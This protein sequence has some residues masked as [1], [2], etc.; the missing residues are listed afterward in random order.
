MVFGLLTIGGTEIELLEFVLESNGRSSASTA[1]CH[2]RHVTKSCFSPRWVST[3]SDLPNVKE[4]MFGSVWIRSVES[5]FFPFKLHVPSLLL[6]PKCKRNHTKSLMPFFCRWHIWKTRWSR[7]KG[8]ESRTLPWISSVV[9]PFQVID[10]D[11]PVAMFDC[12]RVGEHYACIW[13][14]EAGLRWL[15]RV[16]PL[17]MGWKT[18]QHVGSYSW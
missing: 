7:S 12:R 17:V 15:S 13:V 8:L 6:I 3:G 4:R 1:M 5:R 11:L 2:Q 16:S 14:K 10:G 18:F 9:F